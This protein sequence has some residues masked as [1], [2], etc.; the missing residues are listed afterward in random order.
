MQL[1]LRNT[2]LSGKDAEERLD[3]VAITVNRNTVPYDAARRRSPR[4]CASAPRR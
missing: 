3:Q 4:A 1:D 2:E